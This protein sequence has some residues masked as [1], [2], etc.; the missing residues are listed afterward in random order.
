MSNPGEVTETIWHQVNNGNRKIVTLFCYNCPL[1]HYVFFKKSPFTWNFQMQMGQKVSHLLVTSSKILVANT[2]FLVGL[3]TSQSQFR[4]L[5]WSWILLWLCNV[6]G[7]DTSNNKTG[8]WGLM[9]VQMYMCDRVHG[10]YKYKSQFAD[11][12]L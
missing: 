1:E 4:T 9:T 10:L 2:K 8:W 6:S 5:S 3:V 7:W 11:C 12:N